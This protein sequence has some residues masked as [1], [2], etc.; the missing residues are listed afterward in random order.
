MRCR[1]Q[2]GWGCDGRGLLQLS[3]SLAALMVHPSSPPPEW[4]RH[5]RAFL[6]LRQLTFFG[7]FGLAK[8]FALWRSNARGR[9]LLRRRHQLSQRL[10]AASPAFAGPLAQAGALMEQLRGARAACVQLNCTYSSD[11]WAEQQAVWRTRKA[12]PALEAAAVGGWASGWKGAGNWPIDSSAGLYMCYRVHP[13]ARMMPC[14]PS[15]HM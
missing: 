3:L 8:C 1:W 13:L 9:V 7:S 4:L 11:D 10:F 6:R 15:W 5:K 12:K 2:V 14:R